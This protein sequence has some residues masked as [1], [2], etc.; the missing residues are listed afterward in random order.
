M[1]D[2][3]QE[4]PQP[5]QPQEIPKRLKRALE[6][7]AK[8]STAGFIVIWADGNNYTHIRNPVERHLCF[9]D[10]QVQV[11]EYHNKMAVAMQQQLKAQKNAQLDAVARLQQKKIE[12]EMRR[13]N[14][15]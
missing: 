15:R 9:R 6:E 12:D 7:L 11:A 1:T 13:R 8:A 10:M 2:E 4:Q 5:E 14:G 3:Q